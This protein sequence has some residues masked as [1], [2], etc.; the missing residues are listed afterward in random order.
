[1]LPPEE[2]GLLQ[3]ASVIGKTFSVGAASAV[4]GRDEAT[5]ESNLA[6]LVRKEVL[7]VQADPRS[8]ERGQYVFLQDLVRRVAY[9]TLSRR[10]RKARHLA[11]AATLERQWA[12]EQEVA[13]V[14][15]SHYLEAHRAVPDAPD[16]AD[17]KGQARDALI[18]A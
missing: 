3:D 1:G 2:R 16:A 11:V 13:E 10:D 12:E 5:L 18:R 7:G 8:P 6:S 14:L 4:S 17:I 15:A 9:E